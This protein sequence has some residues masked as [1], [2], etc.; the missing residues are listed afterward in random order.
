VRI[1]PASCTLAVGASRGFRAV[2]RDASRRAV[3][4][5]VEYAWRLVEGAGRLER[6]T[7]ELVTFVAPEEPCLVRIGVS[8][9]QQDTVC[10]AEALIT[11][12]DTL[13][14]ET[15]ER[16]ASRQGLP[17]YTLEHAP[18]R[19]WRS[20]YDTER[21]VIVVN[22]GHRDFIFASRAKA[23][24]LR[25]LVRLYAKE[26]VRKNFPGAPAEQLLERL[27]ELSLYAEEHLR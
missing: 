25:Y 8:A 5:G 14:P 3:D 16:T 2:A 6:A 26:M 4:E 27:I 21:N 15:K 10:E 17:G 13:L 20:R 19:L 24:K 7:G 1:A 9:R 22:S 18:G 23:L 12:T 11:I